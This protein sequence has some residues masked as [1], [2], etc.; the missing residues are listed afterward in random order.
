MV[1]L[2]TH[3]FIFVPSAPFS[4]VQSHIVNFIN[5]ILQWM[6]DMELATLIITSC[7]GHNAILVMQQPQQI[8]QLA[9]VIW[10]EV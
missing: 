2:I 1:V 7:Y 4:Y 6:L 8:V 3:F 9:I 10:C 5:F